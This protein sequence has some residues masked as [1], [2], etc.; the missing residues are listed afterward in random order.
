[1]P[2]L[3]DTQQIV[4]EVSRRGKLV[5][6]EPYFTPGTPIVLDPKGLG[7]LDRGDL[8]VVRPGRGRAR[9]E[10]RIGSAK[11]IENVLEALLVEQGARVEFEP[12]DLP[13][14]SSRGAGRSPRACRR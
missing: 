7:G 2:R 5:S 13:A 10:R 14:E 3:G 12:Y 9:V 6:G 4:V 8:A 11:R 1:M